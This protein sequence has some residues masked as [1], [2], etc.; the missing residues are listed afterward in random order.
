MVL[1]HVPQYSGLVIIS[2]SVFDAECFGGRYLDMIYMVSVPKRFKNR[3]GKPEKEY[4]LD[5][6]FPEVMID[7]EDLVFSK[8]SDNY[9]VQLFRGF[10]VPSEGLFY[11]DAGESLPAF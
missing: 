2:S 9:P 1:E 7:T 6:F 3:V 5:G 11:Y 8:M 4:I 10:Q